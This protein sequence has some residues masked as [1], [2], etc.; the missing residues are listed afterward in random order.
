MTARQIMRV[1]QAAE[2]GNV[3]AGRS[4]MKL[5]AENDLMQ[6]KRNLDQEL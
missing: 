5:V 2:V 1:W 4:F 6:V 3:G